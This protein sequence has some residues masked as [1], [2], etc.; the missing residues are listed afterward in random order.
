[1][2]RTI[3]NLKTSANNRFNLLKQRF[4]IEEL[5]DVEWF[6]ALFE[7]FSRACESLK[8]FFCLKEIFNFDMIKFDDE[9]DLI[10]MTEKDWTISNEYDHKNDIHTLWIDRECWKKTRFK[11]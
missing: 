8:F 2:K 10:E 6:N 4:S 1:M 7:S 9:D 5:N 11:I 3:S